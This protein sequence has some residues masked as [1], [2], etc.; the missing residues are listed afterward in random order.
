MSRDAEPLPNTMPP[1]PLLTLAV[2]PG[3]AGTGTQIPRHVACGFCLALP[4]GRAPSRCLEVNHSCWL[5]RGKVRSSALRSVARPSAE[6]WV[7]LA[8][9]D[10]LGLPVL[11][12]LLS[13][14]HRLV[15]C[16]LVAISCPALNAGFGA[17]PSFCKGHLRCLVVTG[18]TTY[19][20]H[21]PQASQIWMCLR[22]WVR[23]NPNNE[24]LQSSCVSVSNK[25]VQMAFGFL[26]S[27]L[28]TQSFDLNA[29]AWVMH[30]QTL[31]DV[32]ILYMLKL[33]GF[34]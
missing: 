19:R 31:R 12:V 8:R 3:F 5:L 13:W 33:W 26:H 28:H 2:L 11:P 22:V 30:L 29:Y 32:C 23:E 24:T 14:M 9:L 34:L 18:C 15:F 6:L 10:L 17:R 7:G 21:Q 1:G 25:K 20:N 27:L 16:L 4:S